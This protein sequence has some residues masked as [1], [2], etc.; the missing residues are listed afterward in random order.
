[1]LK[2]IGA[3]GGAVAIALCWPMATGQL[4]ERIYLDT[5]GQYANPY[6]SV[7]NDS[8]DRGYLSADAVSQ[9]SLKGELKTAFEE[10]GL[11]TVWRIH[12]HVTHG[13]FGISTTSELVMDDSL[14]ASVEQLWGKGVAPFTLTTDTALTRATD[15]TFRVNPLKAD[16]GQGTQADFSAFTL[17]GSVNAD[18]AGDFQYQWP[19]ADLTTVA[20]EQ[21]RL[22]GLQGGGEGRLDGQFWLG[23]QQL[24]LES[25]SFND[26]SSDQSVSMDKLAVSMQNV[27]TEQTGKDAAPLL[28]NTNQVTI[29]RLHS[30]EGET[31]SNFNFQ[32]A[33]TDLDYPSIHQLGEFSE[34]MDTEMTDAE[35]EATTKALDKL[36]AK[37]LKFAISDLSLDTP[38]GAVKSS[39]ALQVKPGMENASQNLM[40]V[41]E[42]INGDLF[43]SLPVALVDADP[44][45]K[46]RAAMLEENGI[47]ERN[48]THYVAK[49]AI[50]GDKL[51]LASGDQLPVA[52][53]LM[54]FM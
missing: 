43:V 18:G 8:Y 31:F 11:P 36:V 1:M 6:L 42:T 29:G 5:I 26:L 23:S 47:I 2:K 52:M 14:K 39:L 48:A 15:F 19:S 53:L 46:E 25:V 21:L 3:V 7:K 27:L 49:M 37:G 30:L 45:L 24:S 10:E 9:V 38:Q 22:K 20:N 17:S 44:L 12:H 51:V 34:K 16:D 41:A 28:T 54:L 13:M 4:G 50:E 40:A 32:L 33:F 35:I